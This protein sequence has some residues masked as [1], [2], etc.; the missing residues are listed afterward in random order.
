LRSSEIIEILIETA[1]ING[2]GY[3]SDN[4]ADTTY[5]A[6]LLDLGKAVT[7]YIPPKVESG[8]LTTATVAGTSVSSGYVDLANT[9]LTVSANVG[10]ALSEVLPEN[11]TIFD[12]Y[13]RAFEVPMSHYVTTTHSGYKALKNDVSHI[14]PNQ[15]VQHEQEGNL[16][17][18]FA[19]GSLQNSDGFGFMDVSYASDKVTSGFFFSENTHYKTAS[20]AAAD[21]NNPFMSFNS[22]YGAHIGYDFTPKYGFKL[23][24]VS[25]RN[26][27]YDGDADF[28]DRNF[29]KSA[30]A[31]DTEV[32]FR[33]SKKLS[34]AFGS[35]ML[36]ED[37]ALLGMNGAGAFGLPESRT[38]YTGVT[39]AFKATPKLTLSGSYYQ[40]YTETQSFN[41]NRLKTGNLI[42]NSF[43]FDANYKL[44]K[45]T[46]VGFRLSSP[47]RIEHGKLYVDMASG[48][49]NYSDE[50]YR[51][52]YAASLKPK[53]R[54]FKFALYGNKEITDNL[55]LSGEIDMRVN[56]E[57]RD[58]RND[59]RALFGMAW[60]F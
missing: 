2:V 36:Y 8:T 53:K 13:Y 47:L 18:S 1:N 32:N 49:D 59:Y 41:S 50:V 16:R 10:D 40:G 30:Y 12:R 46:N 26:G 37:E 34:L 25:G 48:R 20:G 42:S 35:G 9:H 43:A 7:Y 31:V 33:P 5:G 55:S 17:F 15:K 29:K 6:G 4:H 51:N 22:A 45:K 54:E 44:D 27:L 14:V 21:L 23:T 60:N 24:A 56:P 11:L 3:N 52:R 19:Q 38:Y 39:A 28:N 57:H 58:T